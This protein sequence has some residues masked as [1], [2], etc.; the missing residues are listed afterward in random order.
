MNTDAIVR[1]LEAERDRLDTAI[2]AL[3][4]SHVSVGK[5]KRHTSDAA[6][7]KQSLAAKRR[8]AAAKKAGRNKL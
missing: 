1:E 7:R 3:Q 8:W 6:K 4:G 2:A 5:R